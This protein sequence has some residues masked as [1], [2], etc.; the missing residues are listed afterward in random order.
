[1]AFWPVVVIGSWSRAPAAQ[2]VNLQAFPRL[3]LTASMFTELSVSK[4]IHRDV[5]HP[6]SQ[7]GEFS[8]ICGA[9]VAQFSAASHLLGGG[10][11]IR[12]KSS[13]FGG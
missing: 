3:E 1:V 8:W 4:R 5:E 10:G 7:V 12:P 13:F 9:G 6:D 11:S 2:P